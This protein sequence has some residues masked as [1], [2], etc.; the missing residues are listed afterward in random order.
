LRAIRYIGELIASCPRS[1]RWSSTTRASQKKG[2]FSVGVARQYS[3][4]LGRVDNCQIAVSVHLAGE[5]G[6]A[7]I[8]MRLFL[9]EGWAGDDERRRTVGIPAQIK[10]EKK[11]QIALGLIDQA[12]SA[13][14]RHHMVLDDAGYGDATEFR[15][16]LTARGLPTSSV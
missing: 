14:V 15:D 1:R 16:G 7:C 11:W 12:L 3:G 8:G 13:G 10:F 2:E 4:T 6:S 9:P 5:R